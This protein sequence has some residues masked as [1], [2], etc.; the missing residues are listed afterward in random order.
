M[1]S[2]RQYEAISAVVAWPS[3]AAKQNLA[4]RCRRPPRAGPRQRRRRELFKRAIQSNFCGGSCS[5]AFTHEGRYLQLHF[6][7]SLRQACD[8]LVCFFLTLFG[9]YCVDREAQQSTYEI[10]EW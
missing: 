4:P 7:I 5:A 10:T 2:G 1:I 8:Y 9:D 6:E 3:C